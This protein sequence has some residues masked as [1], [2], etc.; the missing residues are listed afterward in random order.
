MDSHT[1]MITSISRMP[2]IEGGTCK[3]IANTLVETYAGS[4]LGD[5]V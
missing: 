2:A 4:C 5:F 3:G 1:A